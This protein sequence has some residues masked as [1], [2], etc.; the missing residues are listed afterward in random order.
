MQ[1]VV[2]SV[3]LANAAHLNGSV[4]NGS[5]GSLALYDYMWQVR[6]SNCIIK[7]DFSNQLGWAD[8]AIAC[9]ASLPA[10]KVQTFSSSC[11]SGDGT[12]CRVCNN[13]I[14]VASISVKI[15]F[16]YCTQYFK[17]SCCAFWFSVHYKAEYVAISGNWNVFFTKIGTIVSSGFIS[18]PMKNDTQLNNHLCWYSW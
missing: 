8:F 18:Y 1:G 17:L 16:C 3:P 4:I 5:A 12:R 15:R 10:S 13:A 7:T 14:C 6:G 9:N 11:L 2:E